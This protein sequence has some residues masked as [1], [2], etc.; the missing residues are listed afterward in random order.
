MNMSRSLS[1]L[2]SLQSIFDSVQSLIQEYLKRRYLRRIEQ[3][4]IDAL[5]AG[6]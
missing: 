1:Q 2:S 5:D 4:K 3:T 6:K